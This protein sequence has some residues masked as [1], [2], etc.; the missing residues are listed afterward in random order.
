[1]TATDPTAEAVARVE[2]IYQELER[3]AIAGT[4]TGS[5]TIHIKNGKPGR[6]E[7]SSQHGPDDDWNV[8]S[9]AFS[10]DALDKPGVRG[11]ETPSKLP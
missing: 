10:R 11:I 1:M 7:C 6:I 5:I 2:R 8:T 3:I 4:F 9:G